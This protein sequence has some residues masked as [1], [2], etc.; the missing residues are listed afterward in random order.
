MRYLGFVKSDDIFKS[1]TR[2]GNNTNCIKIILGIV[3]EQGQGADKKAIHHLITP[4]DDVITL[5]CSDDASN[6]IQK[7]YDS[8]NAEDKAKLYGILITISQLQQVIQEKFQNQIDELKQDT[9]NKKNEIQKKIDEIN[10]E[11]KRLQTELGEVE[12]KKDDINRRKDFRENMNDQFMGENVLLKDEIKQKTNRIQELETE[13]SNADAA[14]SQS[15]SSF[16]E[17][18]SSFI[19]PKS[20]ENE[21]ADTER[22]IIHKRNNITIDNLKKEIGVLEAQ[23]QENSS[24]IKNELPESSE[25]DYAKLSSLKAEIAA[26]NIEL[27]QA[28]DDLKKI[29]DDFDT[30]LDKLTKQQ[31]AAFGNINSGNIGNIG[32]PV[33]GGRRTAWR[34]RHSRR[35]RRRRTNKNRKSRKGRKMLR[36]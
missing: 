20:T 35:H 22:D 18:L 4:L 6:K 10:K 7:L 16:K 3:N 8:I 2:C 9:E 25:D 33:S 32:I 26:K 34:R 5:F 27:K 15:S 14:A 31:D 29:Q 13:K 19:G 23:I 21:R 24:K 17:V 12:N 1:F 30:E 11:I 36:N 28:N